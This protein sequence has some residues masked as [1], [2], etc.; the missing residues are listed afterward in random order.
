[1]QQIIEIIDK[2]KEQNQTISFAES[3]TG[4]LIASA[5]TAIS[6]VS[7]VFN[8]SLVTYSNEIKHKWLGVDNKILENFGAVSSRCVE[9]MLRGIK[10]M[11]SSD[12]AIAISGIAGPTGGSKL[13]PVGTVYIGIIT[14]TNIK[15]EKFLFNGDRENIQKEAKNMAILMI[16]RE[17][18]KI[19]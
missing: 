12:Y 15:V 14:P 8:G 16:Y 6:G 3:C 2:L 19:S 11:S 5:F 1:M 4:G 9:E 13:K 10:S 17:I 7:S 18:I